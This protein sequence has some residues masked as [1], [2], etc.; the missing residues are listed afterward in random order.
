MYSIWGWLRSYTHTQKRTSK[1]QTWD[2]S[3]SNPSCLKDIACPGHM[4]NDQSF[5]LR[6]QTPNKYN[7]RPTQ[8]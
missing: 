7:A 3:G 5:T 6:K 4:T 1:L 2:M 8:R